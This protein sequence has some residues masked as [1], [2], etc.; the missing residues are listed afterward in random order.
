LLSLGK[1]ESID[2]ENS[3][4]SSIVS[5]Y[6]MINLDRTFSLCFKEE[7]YSLKG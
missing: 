2:V 4:K 1:A 3:V 7:K 6:F 5:R